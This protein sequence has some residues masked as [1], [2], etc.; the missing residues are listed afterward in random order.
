MLHRLAVMADE[1]EEPVAR[2]GRMFLLSAVV[3]VL[4]GVAAALLEMGLQHGSDA[5]IGRFAFVGE[6]RVGLFKWGV[7]L[8]PVVGGLASGIVVNWL[9]GRDREHGTNQYIAAF[10]RRGGVLPLR[11]PA[12]KA[13]A[14]VGVIASGG[15][16]G[17]EG[18]IAA[19]GAA[20]GSSIAGAFKLSPRL[21]RV[22]LVAGCGGG[23]GAIFQCPLGGALFAASVLYREPEFDADS[24]VPAF[25]ASVLSYSTFIAFPNMG[26]HMLEGADHLRFSAAWELLPYLL[27]GL[28]CGV[29]S[30]FY[31]KCMRVVG[32]GTQAAARIP[33][34]LA[35]AIGGLV[36]GVLGCALPQIMDGRYHFIQNA[37]DGRLFTFVETSGRSWWAWAL[38]FGGVAVVKCA[39]TAF[40][41]GTGGAGGLLGPSVF[42]GGAAGAFV[43]ALLEAVL[44]GAFPENLRASLVA[45]GM[46][47]VLAASMR[48]PMA[49]IVM[50]TEM[51]GS[52]GL[53]VPLML[54][55]VVAYI[56]GR[57]WGLNDAQVRSGAESP[58]HAGD[59]LVHMLEGMRVGDVMERAWPYQAQACNSLTQLLSPLPVSSRPVFVVLDEGRLAGVITGG[60]IGH[61]L[62][63]PGLS[64]LF[65]AS[66]I[67]RT[68][69][70]M[71]EPEQ[72]LYQALG[73][74]K[75]T[76]A[77]VL[78]VVRGEGHEYLGVLRRQAIH[79]AVRGRFEELRGLLHQ[80]HGELA[81]LQEDAQLYQLVLGVAGTQ[82]DTI[83]RIP[84]PPE[85]LG[86]SLRET[87]FR[88]KYLAQVI[89][90][91][92]ADGKLVCPPDVD[93]PLTPDQI[94]L[95]IRHENGAMGA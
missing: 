60:D 23:V 20:I 89:G 33:R 54:V 77:E 74:C 61:V 69:V 84:V 35:P 80:E 65:I 41:V 81:A 29:L 93:M 86:K 45:V 16:A 75:Q 72:T 11:G 82:A 9:C 57:R 64:S 70:A 19:L 36:V 56:I 13:T 5:L 3:G 52:Y 42:I 67:M 55:C 15:S 76:G 27:L 73:L 58:A 50:V 34:W 59:V 28:V 1:F 10:H 37:M 92:G 21:R 71:V 49:A 39:A 51:T 24:I 91:Q 79:E 47:G 26:G 6:G 44:P 8:L 63:Q 31:Y 4:A 87:D 62:S 43:G 32:S 17:P 18:P 22:L 53:I 38:L 12:V 78:P 30:I 46:A 7:L 66:D 14:A 95:V 85:V 25:V 48:I 94:L 68:N 88:K 40:T 83:Q 90:I 2:W